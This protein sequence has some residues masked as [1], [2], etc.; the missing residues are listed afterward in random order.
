M[1]K[2]QQNT[3]DTE[4]VWT[5][6]RSAIKSFLHSRISNPQ[7]VDDVLQ[8][9]LIKTHAKLDTL[10]SEESIKPWLF[11]VAHSA[12]VDFYRKNRGT[13]EVSAEELWY[14]EPD[15]EMRVELSKCAVA[16]LK[17]LPDETAALLIAIE[18]DGESQKSY[19]ADHGMSYSTLKSRVQK[20][21]AELKRL[22][23]RCCDVS[24]DGRGQVMDFNSKSG[25]CGSC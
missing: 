14:A 21:R 7:D 10:K 19:A 1:E 2:A 12:I 9:V 20:G 6:Y 18:M 15:D 17:A 3:L 22:L 4:M 11:R 8:E 24:F 25:N 5:E 16:F 13:N 23:H